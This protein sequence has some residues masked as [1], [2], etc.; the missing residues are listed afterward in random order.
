MDL[1]KLPRLSQTPAPPPGQNPDAPPE[2]PS[3]SQRG[4]EVVPG[5]GKPTPV[6]PLF[7]RCGAQL[8]P[9]MR[10]CSNCGAEFAEATGDPRAGRRDEL[11]GGGMWLEA[12][13]SIGI[14]LFLLLLVPTGFKYWSS[15]VT[16]STFAPYLHPSEPGVYV[17]YERFQNMQTGA[18]TDYKYGD[19][20]D[21]Y[22]YDTAIT[23]F[24]LALILEGII[25][26][27]VRNRWAILAA[28]VF[29][30]GVT[31]LNLWYVVASYTRTSPITGQSYGLAPYHLLAVI[32]GVM[33]T[34]YQY[35]LFVELRRR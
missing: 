26:A 31:I 22:W 12:F 28:T 18:I 15:K 20:F 2:P 1:S 9:G 4:F 13:L 33:M 7:C 29:I 27:L 6:A 25:F 5:Q 11:S 14:G 23:A 24:A 8:A 3:N 30:G 35:R 10:F 21:R 16:G 19:R 32:F 34:A 17:D